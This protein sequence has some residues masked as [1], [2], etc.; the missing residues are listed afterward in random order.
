MPPKP[1]FLIETTL[2]LTTILSEVQERP[3]KTFTFQNLIFR[4]E[5]CDQRVKN[6]ISSKS[7]SAFLRVMLQEIGPY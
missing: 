1:F 5:T 3:E 4:M 6:Q 2:V 7:K